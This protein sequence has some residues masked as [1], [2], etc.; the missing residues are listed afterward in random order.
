[1][2]VEP[3]YTSNILLCMDLSCV[4]GKIPDHALDPDIC[5][6]HDVHGVQRLNWFRNF[7]LSGAEMDLKLVHG[8]MTC[9]P[10]EAE[11][12]TISI[13]NKHSKFLPQWRNHRVCPHHRRCGRCQLE[14]FWLFR[15]IC[16]AVYLIAG[17][18]PVQRHADKCS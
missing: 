18:A 16:M 17:H 15:N 11:K 4:V 13:T 10:L 14:D 2:Y 8:I 5:H 6:V 1:M 12:C 9:N 3:D 7:G